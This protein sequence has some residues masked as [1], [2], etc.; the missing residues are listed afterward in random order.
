MLLND[1]APPVCEKAPV[2]TGPST[3]LMKTAGV[4]ARCCP[5]PWQDLLPAGL[6]CA[7]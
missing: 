4:V 2:K 3:E 5:E 1:E 7:R 6:L